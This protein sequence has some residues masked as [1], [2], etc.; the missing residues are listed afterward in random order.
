MDVETVII[1]LLF[2]SIFVLSIIFILNN[3]A[4]KKEL[5]K[6]SQ[7]INKIENFTNKKKNY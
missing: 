6:C 3:T 2:F 1:A 7:K 4:K 5:F